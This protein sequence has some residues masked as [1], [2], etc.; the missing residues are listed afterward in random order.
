M[1]QGRQ[2]APSSPSRTRSPEPHVMGGGLADDAHTATP[3]RG[4]VEGRATSPPVADSRVDTPPRT[5]D[6]GGASAGDVGAMAS[7]A[8]I[9]IDPISVVPGGDDDLVRDQPQIHLAPGGPETFGAQVAPSSSSSL[10]L[11]R[12]TIN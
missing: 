3:P 1:P 5:T 9:D 12:C 7:L 10:R 6:A 2:G 8:V 11:P 4:A